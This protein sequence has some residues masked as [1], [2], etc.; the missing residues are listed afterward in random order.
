VITEILAPTFVKNAHWDSHMGKLALEQLL[1]QHFYVP[2][3]TSLAINICKQC[4][5][6]AKNN[7]RQDHSLNWESNM[8]AVPPF[9]GG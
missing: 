9:V 8:W 6:C 3:L 4:E 2:R 5:I 7:P 1:S